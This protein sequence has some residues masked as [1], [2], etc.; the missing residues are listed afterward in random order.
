M[1]AH[2]YA[3]HNGIGTGIGKSYVAYYRGRRQDQADHDCGHVLP[4]HRGR[5]GKLV[6]RPMAGACQL[7]GRLVLPIRADRPALPHPRRLEV[8]HRVHQGGLAAVV[9]RGLR[10]KQPRTRG[11]AGVFDRGHSRAGQL[12]HD[13]VALHRVGPH[14][15]VRRRVPLPG[16]SDEAH[17]PGDHRVARGG[18]GVA[19][20][21]GRGQ[22]PSGSRA[23]ADVLS[24]RC[25]RRDQHLLAHRHQRGRLAGQFQVVDAAG[26]RGGPV[27]DGFEGSLGVHLYCCAFESVLLGLPPRLVWPR[28]FLVVAPFAVGVYRRPGLGCVFVLGRTRA[29]ACGEISLATTP[30]RLA[31]SGGPGVVHV[32]P[33]EIV[34]HGYD[35]VAVRNRYHS[36][37]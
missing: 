6:D 34:A 9:L 23:A 31:R 32:R 8:R 4:R 25:V 26:V 19:D 14:R 10:G 30:G 36:G 11:I 18:R 13:Q 17:A 1:V 29:G 33:E 35:C 3:L 20:H 7:G 12:E 28:R 24:P 37:F 15:R 2:V 27:A 16:G 22:R 21:V 5:A